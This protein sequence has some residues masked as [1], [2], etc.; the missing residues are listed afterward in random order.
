[1]YTFSFGLFPF[2]GLVMGGALYAIYHFTLR[3]K[4][5]AR[6]AQAFIFMALSSI[7]LCSVV[8]ILTV[9][10][11]DSLSLSSTMTH[12]NVMNTESSL[13]TH[14]PMTGKDPSTSEA[15]TANSTL[16]IS[17]ELKT[18]QTS[19]LLPVLLNDASGMFGGIYLVGILAMLAYFIAQLCYLFL[20]RK[21]QKLTGSN[22]GAYVYEMEAVNLPFSFGH[23]VF[24][25]KVLTGH[26]R[27]HV[28][29]HELSHVHHHHFAWL[30]ISEL[31]L[32]LNWYNP[33]AWLFFSEM[34]L[35]QEL[36]VDND[37]LASGID[38]EQYQMS[39]LSISTQ[40]GKWLLTQQAFIGEPLKKR[41]LFMNT[42]INTRRA[43]M[44]W[45]F[46][47]MAACLLVI[48][49]VA[50][51]CQMRQQERKHPLQGCWERESFQHSVADY[52]SP[53]EEH[54]YK[55]YGDYGELVLEYS[56]DDSIYISSF[57]L[58]GMEQQVHGDTLTDKHG[59]PIP[60]KL[61]DGVL[62]WKW[63]ERAAGYDR[64]HP[65]EVVTTEQWRKA[66]PDAHIIDLFRTL[67]TPTTTLG[68]HGMN[69]VW[70]MDS[71]KILNPTPEDVCNP[72]RDF[73][74]IHDNLYFFI[75]YQTDYI[76]SPSTDFRIAGDC[77]EFGVKDN[78]DFLL[79]GKTY[80]IMPTNDKDHLMLFKNPANNPDGQGLGLHFYY[81]RIEMPDFLPRLFEPAFSNMPQ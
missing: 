33:F 52:E 15:I 32:C 64:R 46:A 28:L 34:R 44:K 45:A 72:D 14:N 7:T 51:S 49:L 70:E 68:T 38:R 26:V 60:Y 62:T 4:C 3:L 29:I 53:Q 65:E 36:E 74:I 12:E 21:R 43:T 9:T 54:T 71:L 1:M 16:G 24:L 41:L 27:Q 48:T 11:P 80:E 31:L 18:W 75:V 81:H 25:P 42:T 39:L 58:S 20:F 78:G 13:S 57:M 66:T 77:G 50:V 37:V 63:V 56:Q 69:G 79:Q 23:H 17:L 73:L 30:C 40:R 10:T 76:P 22:Q 67:C 59:K 35:Q 6:K 55:F 5:P 2:M 19:R 8:S 47:S 61:D